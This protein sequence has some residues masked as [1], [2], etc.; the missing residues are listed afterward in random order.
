[1]LFK[2]KQLQEEYYYNKDHIKQIR[3]SKNHYENCITSKEI[4][5]YN[6]LTNELRKL[7]YYNKRL[8]KFIIKY[9]N[10]NYNNDIF[11]IQLIIDLSDLYRISINNSKCNSELINSLIFYYNVDNIYFLQQLKRYKLM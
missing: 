10:F 5:V 6:Y 1:M 2:L 8:R 11:T 9:R 4:E 7:K 3:R